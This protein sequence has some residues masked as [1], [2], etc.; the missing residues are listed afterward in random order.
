MFRER[1]VERVV[2]VICDI[3]KHVR[4]DI[5]CEYKSMTFLDIQNKDKSS[6]LFMA[7]LISTISLINTFAPQRLVF[8]DESFIINN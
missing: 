2:V 1:Q 8:E 7:L 4:L 5:N 3:N 6:E